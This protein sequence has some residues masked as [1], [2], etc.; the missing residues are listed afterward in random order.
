M[1]GGSAKSF[2]GHCE[3]VTSTNRLPV[4]P[5]PDAP[6]SDAPRWTRGTRDESR[7]CGRGLPP[8]LGPRRP[9]GAFRRFAGSPAGAP[10]PPTSGTVVAGASPPGPRATRRGRGPR[11]RSVVT[12]VASIRTP[13]DGRRP[14]RFAPREGRRVLHGRRGRHG[15]RDGGAEEGAATLGAPQRL[16]PRT[17]DQVLRETAARAA[18]AR[19]ARISTALRGSCWTWRW[20]TSEA[21]S[22]R[23]PRNARTSSGR[24]S[25][26]WAPRSSRWARR[27][28]PARTC[29]RRSTSTS[30]RRCRTLCPRSRTRTRSTASSASSVGRWRRCSRPSRRRPSPPRRS[31]Q[32]YRATLRGSGKRKSR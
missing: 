2:R 31:G 3:S 18:R 4:Y 26:P 25:P 12:R 24:N 1:H 15:A 5:P 13:R 32:V 28:R 7:V 10:A 19:D 29:C 21:T 23:T 11:G 30:S 6:V 8:G 9:S 17:R 14:R 16:R 27:C 20:T 22:R